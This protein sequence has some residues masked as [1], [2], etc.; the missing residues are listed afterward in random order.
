MLAPYI[1]KDCVHCGSV[2][3]CNNVNR[4]TS[5]LMRVVDKVAYYVGRGDYD[6]SDGE[7]TFNFVTNPCIPNGQPGIC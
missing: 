6:V 4:V 2:S 5:T 3:L 7:L 1:Q